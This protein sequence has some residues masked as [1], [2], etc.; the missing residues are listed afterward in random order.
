MQA[1]RDSVSAAML[2]VGVVALVCAFAVS[3]LTQ[4]TSLDEAFRVRPDFSARLFT[5]AL[6]FGCASAGMASGSVV[7]WRLLP[8]RKT[9]SRVAVTAYALGTLGLGLYGGA[10]VYAH[11]LLDPSG[12]LHVEQVQAL[13]EELWL[14]I[15][16]VGWLFFFLS[17]LVM[18]AVGMLRNPRVP[19]WVPSAI[20]AFV[21]SQFIPLPGGH[22]TSVAQFVVLAV[23]LAHAAALAHGSA[24][25]R[26]PELARVW[27]TGRRRV[28]AV[29]PVGLDP[30]GTRQGNRQH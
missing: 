13:R 11:S 1:S 12:V 9:W 30:G 23:A 20:L 16:L 29:A 10:L 8:P 19:R 24:T 5:S 4:D 14:R 6:M 18:L 22:A 15:L 7:L 27:P 21:A 17:G 28:V 3:P 26:D 25:G 2:C